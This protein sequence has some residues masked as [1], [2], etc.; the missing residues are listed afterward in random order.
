MSDEIHEKTIALLRMQNPDESMKQL[1]DLI[2]AYDDFPLVLFNILGDTNL[3]DN[4]RFV[5]LTTLCN[6]AVNYTDCISE[7]Y[8]DAFSQTAFEVAS[9]IFLESK[10]KFSIFAA[11]LICN[12]IYYITSDYTDQFL[13]L[14]E[15]LYQNEKTVDS[16][17]DCLIEFQK[18]AMTLPVELLSPL[19]ELITSN[20]Q[21]H[22]LETILYY[23]EDDMQ[24]LMEHALPVI[25]E[26]YSSFDITGLSFAVEICTYCYIRTYDETCAEF[27]ANAITSDQDVIATSCIDK[28]Y[29]E[30][31]GLYLQPII[32]DALLKRISIP[33]PDPLIDD[34][35]TWSQEILVTTSKT[36]WGQM[37]D[38]VLSFIEE[39]DDYA[40]KLRLLY[41]F[42]PVMSN[43]HEF[44]EFIIQSLET[45]ARGDGI[46]ALVA[47]SHSCPSVREESIDLVLQLA[48]DEDFYVQKM[49]FF[50]LGDFFNGE[51]NASE[52]RLFRMI[53]IYECNDGE[54]RISVVY[55]LRMFVLRMEVFHSSLFGSFFES[56]LEITICSYTDINLYVEYVYLASEMIS[57]CDV[58]F[59]DEIANIA[60]HFS[61]VLKNSDDEDILASCI[62]IL[63][64]ISGHYPEN[65]CESDIPLR[66]TLIAVEFIGHGELEANFWKLISQMIKNSPPILNQCGDSIIEKAQH[67]FSFSKIKSSE[68]I[69]EILL[70]MVESMNLDVVEYFCRAC[71]S[72]IS[73]APSHNM[74]FNKLF[75]SLKDILVKNYRYIEDIMLF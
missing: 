12:I 70:I 40:Y 2:Q 49:S 42:L 45:E 30:S 1:Y 74:I 31:S 35:C 13:N 14:I 10:E 36:N 24:Y 37:K 53:E 50:A 32:I 33:N 62:E 68:I 21:N 66:A 41:C 67:E 19:S 73:A 48:T 17:L 71:A 7:D 8:Y 64:S 52:E 11:R 34:L 51:F 18:L 46:C 59:C 28:L 20:L 47:L 65:I 63:M 23:I 3:E 57:K 61:E 38:Q 6:M 9:S 75:T 43:S 25:F 4:I 54:N 44:S 22:A 39:V 5:S 29:D 60:M 58:P 55:L 27:I 56:I 69:S 16:A 26:N 72:I 15:N